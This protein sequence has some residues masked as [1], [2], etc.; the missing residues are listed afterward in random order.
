MPPPPAE[1]DAPGLPLQDDPLTTTLNTLRRRGFGRLLVGGRALSFEELGP[2]PDAL[3]G[4]ASVAVVVDRLRVAPDVRTRLTDSIE[5]AFHEGD[6]AAFAVEVDQAGIPV[7]T[8]RFSERFECRTCGIPYEVP[9]PRLF[10]FNNPFGACPTCHGFGN[11]IELDMNLV[12]PDQAAVGQRRRDRAVDETALS[13]VA[14]AAA[15]RRPTTSRAP[16]RRPGETS[17]TTSAASSSRAKASTRVFAG[18]SGGSSAR[19]TRCTSACSSAAT[20]AT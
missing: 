16:R 8:H 4:A 11:I 12:V 17:P 14:H 6:G 18:F 3:V 15:S 13:L 19:S 10:S 9:E 7:T 2:T 5:T 1:P 20:A